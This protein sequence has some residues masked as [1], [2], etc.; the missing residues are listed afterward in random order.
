MKRL[1]RLL[2]FTSFFLFP[3]FMTPCFATSPTLPPLKF[4]NQNGETQTF[5]NYRGRPI[6]LTFFFLRCP[7]PDYC[8]AMNHRLLEVRE[9]MMGKPKSPIFISL[10]FDPE[11]DTP[12]ALARYAKNHNIE[13]I[14]WIFAC[15]PQEEV[16]IFGKKFGLEFWRD[17]GVYTHNLR[18]IVM[19]TE[20][21]PIKTFVGNKWTSKELAEAVKQA[22]KESK[23]KE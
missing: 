17:Q 6:V 5:E 4:T 23:S 15:A 8:P 20:G 11:Y 18:T 1:R 10:S 14:D 13:G 12:D 7:L 19:D 21:R 16:R 2:F 9:E 22:G 3:W